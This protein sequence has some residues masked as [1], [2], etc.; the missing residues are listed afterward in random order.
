MNNGRLRKRAVF[1][2]TADY[3]SRIMEPKRSRGSTFVVFR[4]TA[5]VVTVVL[6]GAAGMFPSIADGQHP[7]PETKVDFTQWLQKMSYERLDFGKDRELKSRQLIQFGELTPREAG[8]VLPV[9]VISYEVSERADVKGDTELSLYVE[10]SNPHLVAN[11]LKFVGDSS[12]EHLEAKV[13]GDEL[14]YP[15]A[16]LDGM[17]LPDL[18]YTA[19]VKRGFLAALGTK[20]TV[21]VA[22]RTVRA[23]RSRSSDEPQTRTYEIHGE[24]MVKMSLMGLHVKSAGFSS[25]LVIDPL[26]GPVEEILEHDDGGRTEI[27]AVAVPEPSLTEG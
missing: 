24:I 23:P 9:R 15:G 1:L 19:K 22:E 26:T 6:A 21:V 20:I 3:S 2:C 5:L 8:C 7:A 14:A 17:S 13:F 11:I 12:R 4:K 27:R 10:C 25:H 16:P 18:H